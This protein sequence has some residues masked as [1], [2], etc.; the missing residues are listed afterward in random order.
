[1]CLWVC[2]CVCV[3][4]SVS[5]SICVSLCMCESVC[6]CVCVCVW[7]SG[8]GRVTRSKK[9]A[10]W[11]IV[12]ADYKGVFCACVNNRYKYRWTTRNLSFWIY[13]SYCQQTIAI[14]YQ[15]SSK[16]ATKLKWSAYRNLLVVLIMQGKNTV[17]RHSIFITKR[18][19]NLKWTTRYFPANKFEYRWPKFDRYLVELSLMPTGGK[20]WE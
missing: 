13:Q 7:K 14:N 1:M 15:Q 12:C 4:L 9:K 11:I 20:G 17:R 6:V 18:A 2:L 8:K 5:L 3:C 19:G 10:T 16:C